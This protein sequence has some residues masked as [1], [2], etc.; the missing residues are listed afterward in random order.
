M[1][2]HADALFGGALGRG[3]RFADELGVVCG[4]VHLLV[5]V[6]ESG[7]PGAVFH[8]Q[9]TALRAA[10]AAGTGP[11]EGGTRALLLQ[12]QAAARALVARHGGPARPEHLLVA[13]VDQGNAD[14]LAALGNAGLT[15]AATRVAALTVLGLPADLPTLMVPPLTPAGTLDRPPFPI[16]ELDPA[17]WS[18]LVW[19][20]QR[21]PVHRLRSRS[22]WAGLCAVEERAAWRLC[23]RSGVDDDQ[24][25]SLVHHHRAAVEARLAAARPDLAPAPRRP[26][27]R[28][29]VLHVAAGRGRRRRRML[30]FTVGWGTWFANRRVGLR[31]RWFWLT[32]WHRYRHTPSA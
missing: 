20:Q 11:H 17:V 2:E 29:T 5:G 31:D 16:D 8:D 28:A 3:F 14:V 6:A 1:D 9:A 12:V 15:V 10:A 32:T 18:R 25:Y 22:A 19:R 26:P 24:R 7:D 30:R 13:L 4:P 23:D 21:L 27:G